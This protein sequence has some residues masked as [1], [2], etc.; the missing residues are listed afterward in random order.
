MALWLW[1]AYPMKAGLDSWVQS[2]I[3]WTQGC[4]SYSGMEENL[5]LFYSYASSRLVMDTSTLKR[6]F[7]DFEGGCNT[8]QMKGGESLVWE[9]GLEGCESPLQ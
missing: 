8:P 7:T 4:E 2:S 3:P 1:P 6:R 9:W 5:A